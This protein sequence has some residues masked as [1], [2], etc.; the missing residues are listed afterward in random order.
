M[1]VTESFPSVLSPTSSFISLKCLSD[2]TSIKFLWPSS[3]YCHQHYCRSLGL[4]P[5]GFSSVNYLYGYIDID[6]GCWRR[7][8]LVKIFSWDTNIQNLSPRFLKFCRQPSKIVTSCKSPTSQCHQ[9][10][11]SHDW[12]LVLMWCWWLQVIDNFSKLMTTIK[13]LVTP[14]DVGKRYL[15]RL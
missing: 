2:V 8:V 6:D 11:W 15:Y 10:D 3:K 13:I 4:T 12:S 1:L 7:N 9:H 5:S 14:S